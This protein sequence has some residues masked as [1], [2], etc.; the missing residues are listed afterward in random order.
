[1]HSLVRSNI[2]HDST[3]NRASLFFYD[4]NMKANYRITNRDRIFLSGYSGKDVLGIKDFA[5]DWGNST[6]T[7]RWNHLFNGK[8]FSNT[9]FVYND[10]NYTLNNGSATRLELLLFF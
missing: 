5:F 1:L 6:A 4:L 3:L 8:L 9:S 7:I 10:F 2:T